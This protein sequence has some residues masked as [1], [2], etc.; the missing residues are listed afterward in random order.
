MTGDWSETAV[1]E[2]CQLLEGMP[3]A[4]ELAAAWVRLLS[5]PEIL[6]ELHQNLDSFGSSNVAQPAR[7]HSLRA[8]FDYSWQLL[9]PAEQQTLVR[10][11]YFPGRL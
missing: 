10:A 9:T 5:C 8:V 6:A 1:A 2:I 11:L 4:I 7:H 3:L